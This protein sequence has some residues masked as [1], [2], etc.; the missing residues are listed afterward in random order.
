MSSKKESK[1]LEAKYVRKLMELEPGVG[2]RHDPELSRACFEAGVWDCYKV[3]LFG[4]TVPGEHY[5]EQL[6]TEAGGEPT[7]TL[8]SWMGEL[9]RRTKAN[10]G[11]Y[12]EALRVAQNKVN[13][14]FG[15]GEVPKVRG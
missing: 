10:N 12:F 7:M 9:Q 14:E 3:W 2:R 1:G 6:Y 5:L 15:L 4:D 11:A 13:A 8:R